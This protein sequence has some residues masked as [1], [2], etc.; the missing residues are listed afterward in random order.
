MKKL[1]EIL[2]ILLIFIFIQ[3][4]LSYTQTS[5][6]EKLII[7]EPDTQRPYGIFASDL[8]N[9]GDMDVLSA[10]EQDGKIAWYRNLFTETSIKDEQRILP[11]EFNL[12]QNYPNPFN[13]TTTICFTLPKPSFVTLK[14]YDLKGRVI[15][16]LVNELKVGG[17]YDI[18]WNVDDLPGGIYIYRLKTEDYV[19]TKK[20]ILQK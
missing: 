7:I 3:I 17:M 2:S 20:L 15:E 19:T 18:I 4:S 5:F 1:A 11:D 9:D 16:T 8:D 10:S 14:V 6:S 12:S 13:A